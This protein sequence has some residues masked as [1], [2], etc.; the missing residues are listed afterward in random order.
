EMGDLR[1]ASAS[2]VID[3]RDLIV[4]PGFVDVHSHAAGGLANPALRQAQPIVAQGVTTVVV[5][6]DGVGPVNLAEQRAIF[7]RG[8]IGL[9]AAPLIGHGSVRAAVLGK[10]NRAPS[11]EELDRM[12]AL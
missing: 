2:R 11:P 7:E 6:P 12:T 8:G 10:A 4:A 1:T 9:N 3:A 5:N